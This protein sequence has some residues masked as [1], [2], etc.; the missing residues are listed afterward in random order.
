MAE[1][2]H[3]TGMIEV[4]E[5]VELLVHSATPELKGKLAKTFD[6]YSNDFPEE[7]FWA[8]GPKAPALLYSLMFALM[9]GGEAKEKL[10]EA[11]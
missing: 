6:G 2:H 1:E 4:L 3:M 11:K 7:Y 10:V 9:P 8:T 5:A